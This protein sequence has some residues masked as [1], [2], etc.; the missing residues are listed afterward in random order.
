MLT[1]SVTTPR[2]NSATGWRRVSDVAAGCDAV[3]LLQLQLRRHCHSK[4]TVPFFLSARSHFDTKLRFVLAVVVTRGC[5]SNTTKWSHFTI[6]SFRSTATTSV[7]L[8]V[9]VSDTILVCNSTAT[10][11]TT[12]ISDKT[13]FH[14]LICCPPTQSPSFL[15][16][17]AMLMYPRRG[18]T[19]S[20]GIYGS[21]TCRTLG[22][23][24]SQKESLCAAALCC[25]CP[26]ADSLK[27]LR[28]LHAQ[29]SL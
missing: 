6:R 1:D 27:F 9:F 13:R 4:L 3:M 19:Q 7:P 15:S 12:V 8:K 11:G 21:G 22:P 5:Q 18:C 20:V 24:Y 26:T 23:N 14:D 17:E 10:S 28:L 2:S 29:S 16:C 25:K